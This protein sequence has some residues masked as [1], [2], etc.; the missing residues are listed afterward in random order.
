M[1]NEEGM[2]EGMEGEGG[3]ETKKDDELERE[4]NEQME[5][6]E[7]LDMDINEIEEEELLDET[8]FRK[9]VNE[10]TGDV[11]Y[12]RIKKGVVQII[13]PPKEYVTVAYTEKD[14]KM[15]VPS[16]EYEDLKRIEDYV[17]NFKQENIKIYVLAS[18]I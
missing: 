2:E 1:G 5:I 14:Y 6:L 3:E 8:K 18:G 10:E 9:I 17:L 11:K 12:M 16:P 7:E 4:I 15:R 13:A